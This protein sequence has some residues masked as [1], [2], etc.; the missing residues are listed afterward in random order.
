M[1]IKEM[2]HLKAGDKIIQTR[3]ISCDANGLGTTKPFEGKKEILTIFSKTN[4]HVY[5]S[6]KKIL[7]NNDLCYFYELYKG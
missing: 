5:V 6:G 4:K 7:S 1:K 3:E 2:L